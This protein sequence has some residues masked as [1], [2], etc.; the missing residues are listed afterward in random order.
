MNL[1]FFSVLYI[2]WGSTLPIFGII[3]LPLVFEIIEFL[4]IWVLQNSFTLKI[5]TV[6]AMI[7]DIVGMCLLVYVDN[8][9]VQY[10][11][12]SNNVF[13]KSKSCFL[14][15]GV[16]FLI[17]IPFSLRYLISI[18]TKNA[19]IFKKFFKKNCEN[20]GE[21]WVATYFY[22]IG[23]FSFLMTLL[24]AMEWFNLNVIFQIPGFVLWTWCVSATIKNCT[25]WLFNLGL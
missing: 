23:W 10:F 13:S 2:G 18:L 8:R 5:W 19:K 3:C 11:G 1:C 22:F 20:Y 7:L 21:N 24:V 16:L 6:C 25:K 14:S 17:K 9:N 15:G 4:L 12:L